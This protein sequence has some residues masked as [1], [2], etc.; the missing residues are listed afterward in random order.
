MK[1]KASSKIKKFASVGMPCTNKELQDLKDGKEIALPI[2][3]A[4]QMSAMGL[5]ELLENKKNK[6]EKE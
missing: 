6:I 2:E 4:K 3:V 1:V 5:V